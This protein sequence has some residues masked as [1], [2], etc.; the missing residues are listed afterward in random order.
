MTIDSIV[1]I[2]MQD[3][4]MRLSTMKRINSAA[5]DAA[6]L[7]IAEKMESQIRGLDRGSQNTEDMRNLVRTAEGGLSVI[8]DGLQRIR[9][10]GVQASNG[11]YTE[12]DRE[13]MQ[14]EV[15][16]IAMGINDIARGTQF[17]NQNLLDG[18]FVNRNT[19]SSPDGTGALVSISDMSTLALGIK[20]FDV[21]KGPGTFSLD[22]VDRAIGQVSQTRSYLG[23]MENRFDYTISSNSVTMLNQAAAKSRIADLDV[24]KGISD[25]NKERILN[26][27]RLFMQK[28]KQESAAAP[29]SL[30]G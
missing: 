13:L 28:N 8:N 25:Y 22:D 5:D 21:T 4:M 23:S 19:A 12:S 2:R 10:L 29:L 1:N 30:I 14:M 7:A 6:G 27:A 16:Q 17:N 20:N 3:T 15:D 11:I 18:S 9:E 26:D 24:A